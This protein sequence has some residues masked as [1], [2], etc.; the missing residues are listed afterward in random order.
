MQEGRGGREKNKYKEPRH[1]G[2]GSLDSQTLI[3][4]MEGEEGAVVGRM[5]RG[6]KGKKNPKGWDQNF[7]LSCG[8][9]CLGMEVL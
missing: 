2:G 8:T 4:A 5:Q 3:V 7:C 6:Q 9:L 1:L